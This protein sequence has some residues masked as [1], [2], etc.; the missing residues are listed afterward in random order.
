M[1]GGDH[2]WFIRAHG[3]G[4][5]MLLAL[6]LA[7]AMQTKAVIM[8]GQSLSTGN[9]ATTRLSTTQTQGNKIVAQNTISSGGTVMVEGSPWP[10]GDLTEASNLDGN[11]SPRSGL[12]NCF[13]SLTGEPL[14][15]LH[16]GYGSRAYSQLKSGT[17]Q[18]TVLTRLVESVAARMVGL[19]VLGIVV[20]HG[21]NDKNNASYDDNLLE[22]QT[23]INALTTRTGIGSSVPMF[24]SPM[25]SCTKYAE[26]SMDTCVSPILM[27]EVARDHPTTHRMGPPHYS[28]THA[29]DGIHFTNTSS[30]LHGERIGR[31]LA[32]EYLGNG[33]WTGVRPRAVS[34]N[35]A[36][37]SVQM[38]VPVP[39]L[40][41]DTTA[42]SDPG[43]YGFT[44]TD[45]SSPP[46]ISSVALSGDDTVVI[47]L[48][49]TP[50][51]NNRRIRY[52]YT[53]TSGN[54]AGPTTGMRGNIRDS[55][56]TTCGSGTMLRNWLA[57]FSEAVP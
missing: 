7:L 35:G 28:D 41:L 23:D 56:T 18:F 21:E 19:E 16:N 1:E 32:W 30:R 46:A 26:T 42:V 43:T 50:T 40:V 39:P 2:V 38:W 4:L 5:L 36:V 51:G 27:Y 49:S 29:A 17:T 44:Y 13:E 22:W 10:L 25:G 6:A 34:A 45:D 57:H 11:E 37:I 52:A 47:T 24:L 12:A 55:D 15:V 3:R 33:A 9:S 8:T 20:I 31:Q 54:N 48:A 53:G 14:L